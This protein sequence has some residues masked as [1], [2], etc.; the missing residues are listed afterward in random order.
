MNSTISNNPN[1]LPSKPITKTNFAR[2]TMQ[3]F[4]DKTKKQHLQQEKQ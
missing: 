1:G 2:K 3:Y 4:N